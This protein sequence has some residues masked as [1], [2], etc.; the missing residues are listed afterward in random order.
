MKRIKP[1]RQQ[2]NICPPSVSAPLTIF[3]GFIVFVTSL[4]IN[5]YFLKNLPDH[6]QVL[7]ILALTSLSIFAVDGLRYKV[8]NWNSTGLSWSQTQGSISRSAVKFLGLLSS[9]LFVG[10]LYLLFPE[11]HGSFYNRYWDFLILIAPFWFISA[12]IYIYIIDS[13]MLEPEDSYYKL[14]KIILGKTSY[15]DKKIWNHL[16]GWIVKGFF[17]PLMFIYF[18]NDLQRFNQ[19]NFEHLNNFNNIYRFIYDF[20]FTIDVGFVS[21]GYLCSFRLFDTHI[22]ST[23]PTMYGWVVALVCYEPFWSL[24]GRQYIKYD[25]GLGWMTWLEDQPTLKI[26]WGSAILIL[27]GIYVWAS[28]I[29]GARFSNLTHRGIITNGPYRFTK[30]PAYISKNLAWW[31]TAV[32]FVSPLGSLDAIKNML[33]L[34]LLNYIYYLRAKTEEAHLS[35]DATYLQYQSYISKNGI[36]YRLINKWTRN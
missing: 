25:S 9:V 14:G 15:W 23:E 16:L 12:L 36:F 28:L 6:Q 18:A 22:R 35:Q 2:I 27:F 26:F 19:L 24:I 4:F 7:F 31:L 21:M 5:K 13:K 10:T 32:P 29:F 1:I 34:L 3:I 11:Y 33:L 20:I 17:F 8:W 30:H